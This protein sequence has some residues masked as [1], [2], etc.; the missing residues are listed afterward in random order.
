MLDTPALI[1]DRLQLRRLEENDLPAL[2]RYANN[3]KIAD[4]VLNIPFPYRQLD[5]ML[6]LGKVRQGFQQRTHFS[7]AIIHLEAAELIGEI[8]LHPLPN[9]TQGQ[10]AYWIAEP[11]WG[12]G[13]ATEAVQAVLS[14]GFQQLHLQLIYGECKRDNLAS[15]RVLE[16]NKMQAVGT[17]RSVEQ[18]FI[19]QED[20]EERGDTEQE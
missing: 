7:F 1:T 6:R 19:K 5:A 2:V 17:G 20:W 15:V 13:L 9:N 10:V 18:Y 11:Y 3:R 16:K 14:F 4:R 12:Q 8:G